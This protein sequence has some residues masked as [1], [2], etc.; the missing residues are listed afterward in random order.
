[1]RDRR[2][3]CAFSLLAVCGLGLGCA[4]TLTPSR[5]A[6][7]IRH[8]KAFLSGPPESLPVFDRVEELLA[9]PDGSRSA[10]SDADSCVAVFSYH[11]RERGRGEAAGGAGPER[12]ARVVLRRFGGAWSV[13]DAASRALEPSWPL[14]P[15]APA[16]F[17]PNARAVP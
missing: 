5:A 13:D 2:L 7:V 8:S 11:W 9:G 4:D 17:W 16:L 12:T 10:S 15:G 14:L 6:T 1:V 3:G